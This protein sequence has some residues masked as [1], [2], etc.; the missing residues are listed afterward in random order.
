MVR[1]TLIEKQSRRRLHARTG[2]IR[3]AR[4]VDARQEQRCRCARPT[5]WFGNGRRPARE[6]PVQRSAVELRVRDDLEPHHLRYQKWAS[7]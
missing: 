1:T 3:A 4:R 5:D 6:Q 7:Q 2:D